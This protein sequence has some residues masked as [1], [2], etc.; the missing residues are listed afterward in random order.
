MA[1]ALLSSTWRINMLVLLLA[2]SELL[3]TDLLCVK[4][5]VLARDTL[6]YNLRVLVHE[7]CRLCCLQP[8]RKLQN[9]RDVGLSSTR[10]GMAENAAKDQKPPHAM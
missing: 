10:Q 1:S 7:H 6:T 4:G 3:L 8:D 9:D 5:A 2:G